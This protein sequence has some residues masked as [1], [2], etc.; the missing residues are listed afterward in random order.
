M[1]GSNGFNQ[2]F[3]SISHE[4]KIFIWIYALDHKESLHC[5]GNISGIIRINPPS[6]IRNFYQ[7]C[8]E[9]YET[10]R[11]IFPFEPCLVYQAI[12]LI[13]L[14]LFAKITHIILVFL[15]MDLGR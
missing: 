10:T 2:G 12:S 9:T 5:I 1:I 6:I 13:V 14:K 11:L 8:F 3:D 15:L 7:I 4:D